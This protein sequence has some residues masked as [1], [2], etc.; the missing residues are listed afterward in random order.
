MDQDISKFVE[1]VKANGTF[2]SREIGELERTLSSAKVGQFPAA[3]EIIRDL[4]VT[5]S[6]YERKFEDYREGIIP[7]LRRLRV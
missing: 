1:Y 6:N 7:K 2:S 4:D 5:R 3:D